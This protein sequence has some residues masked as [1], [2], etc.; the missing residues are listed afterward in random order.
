M[1]KT[2]PTP[3]VIEVSPLIS[4]S[5][6]PHSA[7][8]RLLAAPSGVAL[9]NDPQNSAIRNKISLN[10]VKD[11]VTG[12]PV[13]KIQFLFVLKEGWRFFEDAPRSQKF[14]KVKNGTHD[15]SS[16]GNAM[17]DFDDTERFFSCVFDRKAAGKGKW[18]HS[19]WVIEDGNTSPVLID[20]EIENEDEPRI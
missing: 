11:P 4:S 10:G 16:F 12:N 8:Y 13:R 2:L 5:G 3:V 1:A 7:S 15:A 9:E 17:R 20:P 18:Q 6:S 14:A 19:F